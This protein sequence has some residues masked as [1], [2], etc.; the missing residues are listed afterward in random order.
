M[1]RGYVKLWRKIQDNLLMYNAGLC[2]LFLWILVHVQAKPSFVYGVRLEPGQ[3]IVGRYSLASRLKEKPSTI[4]NRLE[5]LSHLKIIGLK[6]DNRYTIITLLNWE[7]YNGER[8]TGGQSLDI[9]RTTGGQRVDTSREGEER[10]E[11]EEKEILNINNMAKI[12]ADLAKLG[13]DSSTELKQ[14]K[15]H[16]DTETI[17]PTIEEVR[18][19]C[20]SRQNGIDPEAF[21]AHYGKSGW[22]DKHGNKIKSWRCCIIT[23][24]RYARNNPRVKMTNYLSGGGE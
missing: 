2:Q 13:V 21:I 16:R 6:S 9:G 11:R 5:K 7:L 23:W 10:E 19:Y 14:R 1:Y 22:V 18:Q 24:E 20:D 4:R 15:R 3:V 17:P 8:T 12:E